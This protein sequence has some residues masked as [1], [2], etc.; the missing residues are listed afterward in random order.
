MSGYSMMS[1]YITTDVDDNINSANCIIQSSNQ[2]YHLLVRRIK[3][4][5]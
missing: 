3:S 5:F 4:D 2:F 1:N